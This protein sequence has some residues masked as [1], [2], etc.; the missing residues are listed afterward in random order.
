MISSQPLANYLQ[1]SELNKRKFPESLWKF[2]FYL[3]SWGYCYYLVMEAGYNIVDDPTNCFKDFKRGMDV[4]TD[5][6][7]LY[8]IQGSFYV[9]S[10]YATLYMDE[11]RKDTWV[12]LIHHAV[13]DSLLFFSY[14]VRMVFRLYLYPIKVLYTAGHLAAYIIPDGPFYYSLNSLLW[15][16]FAMNI[17]WFGFISTSLIKIAFGLEKEIRDSRE[18]EEEETVDRIITKE[19]HQEINK[20]KISFRKQ[21]SLNH[22]ENNT[23]VEQQFRK[24]ACT[25]FSK[26]ARFRTSQ[27]YHLTIAS[28]IVKL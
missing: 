18:D 16:L 3:V 4:P 19:T 5:F 2:A 12:M 15:I 9:H 6:K 7:I 27:I 11:R 8:L 25:K 10:F 26:L 20:S 22:T 21:N 28:F 14:S 23:S 24:Y 17:Y 13:A 1:L